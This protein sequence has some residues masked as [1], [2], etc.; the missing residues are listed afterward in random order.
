MGREE[1]AFGSPVLGHPGDFSASC[2]S[3]VVKITYRKKNN[4]R[5]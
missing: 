3:A 2:I 4:A 1:S 5:R